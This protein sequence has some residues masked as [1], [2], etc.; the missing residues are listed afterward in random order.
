MQN[1]KYY[2]ITVLLSISSILNSQDLRI[3]ELMPNNGITV[4]DSFDEN[5]DWIEIYNN[6]NNPIQISDYYISNDFNDKLKWQLPNKNLQPHKWVIIFCS[7]LDLYTPDY[8]ANFKLKNE[9]DTV[10]IF[11]KDGSTIDVFAYDSLPVDVSFGRETDGSNTLV[12][13]DNPT[14]K[15][16]NNTSTGFNCILEIPNVNF[17]S[18]F[19]PSPLNVLVN[20]PTNGVEL[21][22]SV[23]GDDPTSSDPLYSGSLQLSTDYSPNKFCEIPTNPALN[24]PVATYSVIRSNNRGWLA[25]NG[26][27]QNVNVLK[28]KAFKS[29]CISSDIV[30]RTYFLDDGNVTFPDLPIISI[31]AD[32]TGFF[33]DETGIYVYGN[34]YNGNYNKRGNDWERPIYLEYFDENGIQLIGQKIGGELHGNGSR[35]ST[36]KNIRVSAK[37]MYG[38]KRIEAP[39]FDDY[40]IEEFKYLIVRSP[41]HRPDC[42]PRDELATSIVAK[43]GFDIQQYKT[44]VMYLNGEFWGIHTIKERFNEDYISIKYDMD[45]DHIV[46]IE[47]DG[48]VEHG[49]PED[50]VHY[51]NMLD[52]VANNSLDIPENMEYLNTQMDIQNYL[53]FMASEIYIGNGDWPT[54][55]MRYWRKRVDYNDYASL[56]HDG[57]WRWMFF[58]LDGGF[59][60]TCEDVF[61]TINTLERALTDTGHFIEYTQFFR[62]LT[63]YQSFREL[64][65]N[66]SCDKLNSS[67]LSQ[68]AQ[69]KLNTIVNDLNLVMTDHVNRWGYPSVSTTLADRM[70]ETPS[71]TKW[72]YLVT[73]FDTFITKRAFYVRRHMQEKWSLSDTS[74]VTIDVNNPTMGYVQLNTLHINSDL[75]GV[76]PSVYPW[77]GQY[78]N[79]IDIPIHAHAYPGYRFVEWLGTPMTSA[80]TSINITG[81]STFTAI[82]EVDPNYVPPLPITI[83]EIQAWNTATV[84]DEDFKYA[85]WIELYNPNDE[86]IDITNYYL[87]DNKDKLRKYWIGPNKTVIKA[88]E[89]MV[90]WADGNTG[91]GQNHTNFKLSKDGEMV[92]LV[93]PNGV[94]VVDS[95]SFGVQKENYSFGRLSDGNDPWVEFEYPTPFYSNLKTDV[96]DFPQPVEWKVYPNPVNGS[97]VYFN[98]RTSGELYNISGVLIRHFENSNSLNLDYI[99]PGVYILRNSVTGESIKLIVQ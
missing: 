89:F 51:F 59:G 36:Q 10:G 85:D 82:F 26:D 50:T 72:N 29:G 25:P 56:G 98:S 52:F 53:D 19:Y 76:S 99:I 9:S 77:N 39:L 49:Y 79:N 88:K 14:P 44:G 41:G 62:D 97:T 73:R 83:N 54:N 30:S 7:D 61:Y 38:K 42:M 47:S 1:L 69:P 46:L 16:T 40:D 63:Q 48:E 74:V 17:N 94:T 22:Y 37:S 80:D 4:F 12:Y 60:G 96:S 92:A 57:R 87:T 18:G 67:F 45:D 35:H 27:Q 78:F 81:D 11:F 66:N 93:A 13:F 70:N 23:D 58:D 95:I 21:R 90:F 5:S 28:V 3:N 75:E 64:Y 8:H 33:S 86:D 15:K 43:L 20:H 24:A 32:S 68:V 31:Q 91:K 65:I 34:A 84:F 71:L 6:T 55:N 2:I